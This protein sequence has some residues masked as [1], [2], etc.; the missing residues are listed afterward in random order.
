MGS[1]FY[2][3]FTLNMVCELCNRNLYEFS[4]KKTISTLKDSG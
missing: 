1:F 4:P 3:V 2:G